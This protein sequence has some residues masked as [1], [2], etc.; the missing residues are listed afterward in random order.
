MVYFIVYISNSGRHFHVPPGVQNCSMV[1]LWY[2]FP[3]M[4]INLFCCVFLFPLP[5]YG[6]KEI[7]SD[8]KL[9]RSGAAL[10][11]VSSALWIREWITS[12]MD[13]DWNWPSACTLPY[14][15]NPHIYLWSL[16][17][18]S[19]SLFYAELSSFFFLHSKIYYISWLTIHKSFVPAII[20]M[21][22]PT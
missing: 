1:L 2:F 14:S 21:R 5:I 12:E 19:Y 3:I 15:S 8:D 10:V 22:T 4:Y 6:F 18:I 11:F 9:L 20:W 16:P 13:R 17:D 7:I